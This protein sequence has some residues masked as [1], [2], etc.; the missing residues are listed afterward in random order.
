MH[1]VWSYKIRAIKVPVLFLAEVRVLQMAFG[2]CYLD[3]AAPLQVPLFC[4]NPSPL[5]LTVLL[6][7]CRSPLFVLLLLLLF[8]FRSTTPSGMNRPHIHMMMDQTFEEVKT[9][10]Q[11]SFFLTLHINLQ[12]SL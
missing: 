6:S 12:H 1:H 2:E 3:A 7:C 4:L 11:W 9:L 10:A 8:W 5:S